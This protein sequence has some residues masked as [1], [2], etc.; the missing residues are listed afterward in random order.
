MTHP[1]DG[2]TVRLGNVRLDP[3]RPLDGPVGSELIARGALPHD[4]PVSW[5]RERP[6]AVRAV[7]RAYVDAGAQ[8][9]ITNTFLAHAALDAGLLV[10]D[11]VALAREAA[12]GLPVV[13]NLGPGRSVAPA[14][15]AVYCRIAADAGAALVLLEAFPVADAVAVLR[16]ALPAGLPVVVLGLFD[17]C[18]RALLQGKE[19]AG[20]VARILA[21]AGAAGV[22][23]HC[24]EPSGMVNAV[25]EMAAS[26]LPVPII[27]RPSAGIPV[28]RG[29]R[30]V[31]PWAAARWAQ[32]TVALREQ[33]A[34]LLGG[35]CGAGP[36]HIAALAA[37][38]RAARCA[39][40]GV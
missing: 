20:N 32:A 11:G 17:V 16:A 28:F 2:A 36:A 3:S 31:Y 29:E 10:R 13:L 27:A 35:C 26:S 37:R 12:N 9:V 5:N 19:S 33:G 18:G 24:A 21:K 34:A 14:D 6:E 22:G 39:G 4:P 7:H 8:W 40:I 30:W 23:V 38:L 1:A 15:Y 25:T